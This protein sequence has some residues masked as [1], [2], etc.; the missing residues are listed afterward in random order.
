MKEAT[1]PKTYT[2]R[3]RFNRLYVATYSEH[4]I[5]FVNIHFC[6][7]ISVNAFLSIHFC[8]C[9]LSMQFCLKVFITD[10]IPKINS[11]PFF[12]FFPFATLCCISFIFFLTGDLPPCN[13]RC[14]KLGCGRPPPRNELPR[15]TTPTPLWETVPL[16]AREAVCLPE[17]NLN[18]YAQKIFFSNFFFQ[19][20][21]KTQIH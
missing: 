18:W 14:V 13:L 7:C 2:N 10:A 4:S 3:D 8:Q 9:M 17:V 20:Q 21:E 1:G 16:G 5:L 12:S 15:R 6:Q 19:N 11:D